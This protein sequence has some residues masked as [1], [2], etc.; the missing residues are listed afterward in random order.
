M[1][2]MREGVAQADPGRLARAAHAMKG[3]GGNLGAVRLAGYCEQLERLGRKGSTEGAAAL[4][5]QV[6]A[7][8]GRLRA[9][10]SQRLAVEL[11]G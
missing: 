8:V 9:V 7:E 6:I 11:A 10:F 1:E 4:V 5:T 2:A 3:G